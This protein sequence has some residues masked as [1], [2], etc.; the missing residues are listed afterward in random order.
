MSR[1]LFV[2]AVLSIA[3][4]GASVA[5]ADPVAWSRTTMAAA[6]S[7]FPSGGT[8]MVVAVGEGAQPAA[9]ALLQA[10]QASTQVELASDASAIGKVD[11]LSDEQI[12][13]RAFARPIQRVAIVRV[14]PAGGSVKA[15]VTVYAAQGQV[16]TAFTLMPGKD[17]ADNP[18]PKAASDGVARDEMQSVTASV[19]DDKAR[20]GDITYSRQQIVGVSAYGGLL[21]FDSVTFAKDGKPISDTPGLYDAVGMHA[22]ATSYRSDLE[23]HEKW[24]W[25]GGVMTSLGLTGVITFGTWALLAGLNDEY[26]N[27]DMP[28]QDDHTL[29]WGLTAA[30]A[31]VMII[32]IVEWA[33]HPAPTPLSADDAISL[34]DKHNA[35]KKQTT[36]LHFAPVATPTGGGL[37]FGGSW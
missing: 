9:A 15:V 30:S 21:Q 16:T 19:G 25:R 24:G 5:A 11:G 6:P 29:V 20:G 27:S 34:V 35:K 26:S 32:G 2:A 33:S 28:T 22:E 14:F 13:K 18:N 8:A 3:S 1:L 12:V 7:Y 36:S 31:G 4:V 17:L 37:T 23:G 10:L